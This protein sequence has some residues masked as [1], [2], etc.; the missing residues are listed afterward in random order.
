MNN[1][2][3][4]K[5]Y[6]VQKIHEKARYY[7]GRFLNHVAVI[8]HELAK[9][10]TEYFCN[11]NKEKQELFFENIAEEFTL[12]KKKVLIFKI[13]QKDYPEYWKDNKNFLTRLD[14]IQSFRNKLA[15]SIVDVSE[16]ALNR[17]IEDGISFI[18][19]NKGIPIND[20]EFQNYEVS[21][22]MVI[23]T[24]KEI[25]MLLPFKEVRLNKWTLFSYF[26]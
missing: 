23:T 13:V 26:N 16:E 18:N 22:N 21:A 1:E 4:V 7:R 24:L 19:W 25:K 11:Y 10:L 12:E 15:N 20:K 14:K 6:N 5:L 2:D 9:L 8:E 3:D 17:P